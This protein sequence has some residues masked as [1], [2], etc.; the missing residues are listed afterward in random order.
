MTSPA[1][2]DFDYLLV[3]GGLGNALI[4]LALFET[5]PGI[6]VA[7]VEQHGA[8][9]GNHL[10]CFHA[11]DVDRAAQPFVS[12]LVG[13][14][15]PRYDVRFPELTRTLEEAYAAVRSER[16]DQ[17][18]REAF[19]GRSGSRLFLNAR[20]VKVGERSVTLE[21]GQE[22]HAATVIE[23]R[24]PDALTAGERAGYQKFVGL[25]LKL[26]RPSPIQHPL[27]MDAQVPQRDGF[28]FLYALPFA[29]DH[30]L[31]EDTYFSESPLLD[32]S[33]LEREILAYAEQN[34]FVV[35]YVARTETG[36]LPLPTRLP[37]RENPQPNGP[38]VAGYQGAW[39]HPVTGYSFPVAARLASAIAQAEPAT[40]RAQVWP[41]LLRQQRSQL[42]FCLLLN[43]LFFD[44]FAP[45][46]RRNVIERFYRLPPEA[47]RRFYAMTLTHTDRAR[48]L[49]GRPPR[50]FSLTRAL[51]HKPSSVPTTSNSPTPGGAVS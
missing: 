17:V 43:R 36:V 41:A 14:R 8:L 40:L 42:R 19:V 22:L 33:G 38:L 39:F 16:L 15:W 2:Q 25:E 37:K 46:E 6:R 12:R 1:R 49:C 47:V 45:E 28:R 51:S 5:R 35:D 11:G 29:P 20:A 50:G 24:G 32:R 30:V 26:R 23:S 31:L 34:G 44:A 7:L 10:W 18:V 3:G 27:L 21:D 9:G 13:T 48:I 4:A